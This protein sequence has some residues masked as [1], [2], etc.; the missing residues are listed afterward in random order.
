MSWGSK[1]VPVPCADVKH[2]H[3]DS[4]TE[5]AVFKLGAYVVKDVV[6]SALL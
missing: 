2:L 6:G 3:S 4:V 1:H 5:R